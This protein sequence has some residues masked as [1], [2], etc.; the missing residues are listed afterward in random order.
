MDCMPLVN[1]LGTP[2]QFTYWIET[3]IYPEW[4][5]VLLQNST[6]WNTLTQHCFCVQW[7]VNETL[8]WRIEWI[9]WLQWNINRSQFQS[10]VPYPFWIVNA[11]RSHWETDFI[12]AVDWLVV[13]WKYSSQDLWK[14]FFDCISSFPYP[15]TILHSNIAPRFR[16]NLMCLVHA[17]F[18][19]RWISDFPYF[20]S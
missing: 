7:H 8:R 15:Q 18:H 5:T 2:K 14:S 11:P 19:H 10:F 12:W 6:T 20:V 16:N 9:K 4:L 1:S 13:W 17:I 3:F